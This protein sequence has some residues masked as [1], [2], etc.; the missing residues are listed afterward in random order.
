MN[1]KDYKELNQVEK[2]IVGFIYDS[3]I[4]WL[5]NF[6]RVTY[7]KN[8]YFTDFVSELNLLQSE[9]AEYADYEYMDQYEDEFITQTGFNKEKS[10]LYKFNKELDRNIEEY[11]MPKKKETLFQKLFKKA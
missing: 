5:Y 11:N 4:E 2:M 7:L 9:L 1:K 8:S 6:L 10:P 3:Y